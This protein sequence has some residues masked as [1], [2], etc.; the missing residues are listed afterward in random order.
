MIRMLIILLLFFF[1]AK[2]MLSNSYTQEEPLETAVRE[3][4]SPQQRKQ[5]KQN[6]AL[7]NQWVHQMNL[8]A[9]RPTILEW[10]FK[11]SMT[12][13]RIEFRLQSNQEFLPAKVYYK[14]DKV[15]PHVSFVKYIDN[16]KEKRLRGYI[17]PGFT[18]K[19]IYEKLKKDRQDKEKM[20]YMNQVAMQA[21]TN[22]TSIFNALEYNRITEEEFMSIYTKKDIKAFIRLL[23]DEFS[24]VESL[25]VPWL[26]KV[27]AKEEP[28]L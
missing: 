15:M 22:G 19:Q 18:E 27:S 13:D 21:L 17:L 9:N 2:Q 23:E 10:H 4:L 5:R 7:V 16:G 28:M 14:Y 3:E 11:D 20:D 8:S 6:H 24:E 25:D 12:L 1:L 26:F